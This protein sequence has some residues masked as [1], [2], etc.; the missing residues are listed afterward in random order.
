MC[1]RKHKMGSAM[2]CDWLHSEIDKK[3]S[4]DSI[5]ITDNELI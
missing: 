3:Q 1:D 5:E 2:S 4:V